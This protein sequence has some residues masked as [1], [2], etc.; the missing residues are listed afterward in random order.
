MC[1]MLTKL[2][3]MMLFNDRTYLKFPWKPLISIDGSTVYELNNGL[4]VS[5]NHHSNEIITYHL[6]CFYNVKLG[7]QQIVKHSERW[8]VS[9]L[10]AIAQIFTPGTG[11]SGEWIWQGLGNRKLWGTFF[12]PSSVIT[13][14][15]YKLNQI[16]HVMTL[17]LYQYKCK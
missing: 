10:E 6:I 12:S 4:K 7:W 13:F 9:A 14:L 8:N 2:A 3:W 15:Y 5:N 16:A 1:D 17:F 11:K